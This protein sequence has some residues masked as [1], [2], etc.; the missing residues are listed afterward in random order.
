MKID[1]HMHVNHNGV[2]PTGLIKYLDENNLDICW[3]LTWDEAVR[4]RWPQSNLS[5]EDVYDT[6]QRYPSRII[7]MYAP[8]PSRENAV[9]LLHYWHGLGIKGCA[10]LKAL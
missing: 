4:S 9:E 7:P 6:Y 3:L 10:E 5:V 2:T 8:D 1:I